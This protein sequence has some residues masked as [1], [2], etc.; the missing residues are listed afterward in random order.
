MQVTPLNDRVLVRRLEE[1][2]RTA[3]GII[4][5]DNTKEKPAQGQ[6]VAT[7]QGYRNTTDGTLVKLTVKTGDKVIFGKYSG[8]DVKIDGN[9]FLIMKEED[10]LGIIQ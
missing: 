9:E 3:G 6:V 5:P 1:E 2:T 10:I 8:T 7:G 4:I